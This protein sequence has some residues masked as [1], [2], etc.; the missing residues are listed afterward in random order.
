MI[1]FTVLFTLTLGFEGDGHSIGSDKKVYLLLFDDDPSSYSSPSWISALLAAVGTYDYTTACFIFTT[2]FPA[3]VCRVIKSFSWVWDF[4]LFR[5]SLLPNL[6]LR[7]QKQTILFS[8]HL[9]HSILTG[10]IKLVIQVVVKHLLS[11]QNFIWITINAFLK[12]LPFSTKFSNMLN[13]S[14]R[15]FWAFSPHPILLA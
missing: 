12:S 5:L 2:M 14:G 11:C 9:G 1:K 7:L 4:D 3:E 6:L 15:R 10:S 8:V 13:H